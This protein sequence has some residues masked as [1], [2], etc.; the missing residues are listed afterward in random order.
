MS[1]TR[2]R[3]LVLPLRV[4][5]REGH[6]LVVKDMMS[7][8]PYCK[9]WVGPKGMMEPPDKGLYYST[10]IEGT[11]N[12]I[13]GGKEKPS[14]YTKDLFKKVG[15][16]VMLPPTESIQDCWTFLWRDG[17]VLHCQ[18]WHRNSSLADEYMGNV[19]F[20]PNLGVSGPQFCT[21]RAHNG[22][23]GQIRSHE[24]VKGAITISY[25]WATKTDQMVIEK[26]LPLLQKLTF[27][28]ERALS[29]LSQE[30]LL[31]YTTLPVARY[32]LSEIV[33]GRVSF[34]HSSHSISSVPRPPSIYQMKVPTT[35]EDW[36]REFADG[37]D[38]EDDEDDDSEMREPDGVLFLNLEGKIISLDYIDSELISDIKERFAVECSVSVKSIR[39]CDQ[40]GLELSDT[41][42]VSDYSNQTLSVTC[43]ERT[44]TQLASVFS[45]PPP[46][47]PPLP[48]PPTIP[49]LNLRSQSCVPSTKPIVAAISPRGPLFAQ[50]QTSSS[51]SAPEYAP[52]PSSLPSISSKESLSTSSGHLPNSSTAPAI[53][54]PRPPRFS[55][56]PTLDGMGPPK[57][58]RKS[59]QIPAVSQPNP[60]SNSQPLGDITSQITTPPVPPPPP[61]SSLVSQ[62]PVGQPSTKGNQSP[63][64]RQ[65]NSDRLTN[66]IISP[67]RSR[68]FA[69]ENAANKKNPRITI[70]S[71]KKVRQGQL[72]KFSKTFNE[73]SGP[74]RSNAVTLAGGVDES[75]LI[76]SVAS[77]LFNEDIEKMSRVLSTLSHDRLVV[78]VPILVACNHPNILELIRKK[79][80]ESEA[81]ANRIRMIHN[82]RTQFSFLDPIVGHLNISAFLELFLKPDFNFKQGDV[83][84]VTSLHPLTNQ[85]IDE[86][87][88]VKIFTSLARPS[89]ISFSI[90][91]EKQEP[92]M[93]FKRGEDLYNETCLQA[94]FS[95]MNEIWE[96]MLPPEIRPRIFGLKELPGSTERGFLEIVPGVRDLE[97]I[98]RGNMEQITPENDENFIRTTCGWIIASYFLGISDRHRENTLVRVSDGSAIPIDF[99]FI[100]GNQPPSYNT[101]CITVSSEMY[102]YLLRKDKWRWFGLMFM[103]GFWAVRTRSQEFI[104]LAIHLFQGTDRNLETSARF[105]SYRMRLNEEMPKAMHRIYENLRH[106]PICFFTKKKIE[107]HA[108]SKLIPARDDFIGSLARKIGANAARPEKAEEETGGD[109]HTAKHLHPGK[110]ELMFPLEWPDHYPGDFVAVMSNLMRLKIKQKQQKKLKQKAN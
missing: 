13:W 39:F 93:L 28:D 46:P 80:S 94:L 48:P 25:E 63:R 81:F 27:G 102:K 55:R 89:I 58:P 104:R 84:H 17:Q 105:I 42:N 72:G 12:P 41:L 70:I 23:P 82:K 66:A 19:S 47:V 4:W 92:D 78:V 64:T 2:D 69:P 61:P 95:Y 26:W 73:S 103:A 34:S 71:P 91:G 10:V 100:L 6:K 31:P 110:V 68:S 7:S 75:R 83:F 56:Q 50:S 76:S 49:P 99:G 60:L 108:K 97:I 33:K 88:V 1:A 85:P 62:I 8:S 54:P 101:F 38:D 98:E 53:P 52:P 106:A 36:E 11:R 87:K 109:V 35:Q 45:F 51:S 14:S 74:R 20:L 18:I 96:A 9:L 86:V 21:E 59:T 65:I 43:T 44:C 24:K 30:D 90:K 15:K 5:L 37:G 29:F 40:Q 79:A 57:P 32:I 3:E 16:D 67:P 77:L 107:G 22:P